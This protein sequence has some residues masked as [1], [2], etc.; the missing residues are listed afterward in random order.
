[1]QTSIPKTVE[2]STPEQRAA[3]ALVKR[4]DEHLDALDKF[5]KELPGLTKLIRRTGLT[6]SIQQSN[7]TVDKRMKEV[8]EK[9][10]GITLLLHQTSNDIDSYHNS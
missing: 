3:K 1:M 7:R 9:L 6:D 8:A 2:A 10:E 5:E 4:I